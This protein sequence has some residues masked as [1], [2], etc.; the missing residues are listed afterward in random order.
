[1]KRTRTILVSVLAASCLCSCQ[2]ARLKRV[3]VAPDG[4]SV[5]VQTAEESRTVSQK[6]Y[7]GT[8]EA[9][10]E[11]VVNAS[12]GGVVEKIYVREGQKVA[13]GQAMA[14]IAS[15]TVRSSYE[16]AMAAL[17]RAEDGYGRASKVYESGSVTDVKMVEIRTQLAQARASAEAAENALDECTLRAP[18]AAS[19][20]GV[21]VHEGEHVAIARPMVS[22]ADVSEP[23]IRISVPENEVH[24]IAPGDRA[25][26]YFPALDRTFAAVVK[27]KAFVGDALSHSYKCTL[28]VKGGPAGLLPG[29][30]CNVSL[31]KDGVSGIVIPADVV[32]ID[33]KGRYVWTVGSDGKVSKT[34]ITAGG[35]SGKGVIVTGGLAP[36]DRIIVEGASKVSAGMSVKI[37]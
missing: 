1:M 27:N 20:S 35:F 29:M 24:M 21:F 2:L 28:A 16:A 34:R 12:H 10:K 11:A 15:R 14:V 26:A 32:R 17:A 22:L 33:D 8:L 5:K 37:K 30:I 7:V 3:R 31:E 18:F 4:V 23:E 25:E 13:Q 6:T 9:S 19:V 36:G